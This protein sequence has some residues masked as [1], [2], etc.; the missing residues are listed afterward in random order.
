[1][2]LKNSLGKL[3]LCQK[4][5]ELVV[6]LLYHSC[7]NMGEKSVDEE[8][9]I[10]IKDDE[11]VWIEAIIVRKSKTEVICKIKNGDERIVKMKEFRRDTLPYVN[12][13]MVADLVEMKYLHEPGVLT[14]LISRHEDGKPYTR[15]RDVVISINPF[16]W[17]H[18]LYN[19]RNQQ[20]YADKLIWQIAEKDPRQ[21]LEPHIYEVSALA[22]AEMAF[23]G[24]NQSI[25]I[26][27]E[28]GSGKTEAV[29]LM[30][31]H[32]AR[33]QLGPCHKKS[34]QQ[35][36]STVAAV[37]GG[38]SFSDVV[39]RILYTNPLL[40][41]F[42]NAS[43]AQNENS[44]RFGK[45]VQLQFDNSELSLEQS[46]IP[47]KSVA[48]L[49]G[50]VCDVY[51]LETSRVCTHATNER[52]YHI[53]Y[54]LL[55]ASDAQKSLV[56]NGIVGKIADDFKY[57]GTPTTNAID[58]I[59]DAIKYSET[60]LAL[61]R[62]GIADGDTVMLMQTI[63]IVLQL[64]NIEFAAAY[65]DRA[66]VSTKSE[67]SNLSDLIGI[68]T[69]QLLPAFTQRTMTTRNETFNVPLS[70]SSAMEARDA[71]AK[72][73]YLN[74][75]TWLVEALNSKTRSTLNPMVNND[76]H[77]NGIIGLLDIFG[78]ESFTTNRFEQLC[79]NYANEKLQNK[80]L[81]DIFSS[82]REEYEYE[83][84]SL[85]LV[86]V[87]SNE[88]LLQL[89]DGRCGLIAL[90][91]EESYLPKG[92]SKSFTAKV[93]EKFKSSSL[94]TSPNNGI[95][96]QF[97]I[98][99]YAGTV[100]YNTDNFLIS[101]QDTLPIDL[102]NCICKCHNPI[103]AGSQ[104][105]ISFE[106]NEL[107]LPTSVDSTSG[108]TSPSITSPS[109]IPPLRSKLE[110]VK[111]SNMS[112]GRKWELE[113]DKFK[114]RQRS[115]ADIATNFDSLNSSSWK[116]L[117]MKPSEKPSNAM[118]T[119]NKRETIDTGSSNRIADTVWTKYRAQLNA[120][121]KT[122]G[123]THSRYVRCIKPNNTMIPRKCDR[124][125]ISKQLRYTGLVPT[126]ALS[127]A[128]FTKSISNKLLLSKFKLL[129]DV[130]KF[131]SKAKRFDTIGARRKLDCEALLLCL[132]MSHGSDLTPSGVKE[133]PYVVG[134]TRSYF[135][136][137]VLE[138]LEST[139]M[140][141]LERIITI[142]QKNFRG[143]LVRKRKA[144]MMLAASTI[145]FWFRSIKK[146]L[147]SLEIQRLYRGYTKKKIFL[148]LKRSTL[149]TQRFV[150]GFICRAKNRRYCNQQDPIP[151]IN[152]ARREIE[153]L[154][155]HIYHLAAAHLTQCDR[156][157]LIKESLE[158]RL[159]MA[160][161]TNRAWAAHLIPLIHSRIKAHHSHLQDI[162]RFFPVTHHD[163]LAQ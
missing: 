7:L 134:K 158:D 41:A 110:H 54:Q 42:G 68:S 52:T 94:I 108:S 112:I 80:A 89:L 19:E 43:T 151:Q 145:Q 33:I 114:K 136:Q 115:I 55:A 144:K 138:W 125:M 70:L 64:G 93:I 30:M 16:R 75:F 38:N 155:Y 149:I 32:L 46:S 146:T 31:H 123:D 132:S 76:Q 117:R 119:S 13:K 9:Q 60:L 56:W 148:A 154:L 133:L 63:C 139:R 92:S 37:T 161:S 50:S 86:E 21:D 72:N 102:K 162:R 131:P 53:F 127:R 26:T 4:L 1:M 23:Q 87:A 157:E 90:L 98:V 15:S 153:A 69:D 47:G 39:D 107:E 85:D 65:D 116:D 91:N 22:Y 57:V 126:I 79:I 122:L 140:R 66:D 36:A 129:W 101:N 163:A 96:N 8:Q 17:L 81:R 88:Q 150:R 18:H 71:L 104:K 51:L 49:V 137:G 120:L 67:F 106:H 121:M 58:G 156:H 3:K 12:S 142:I 78:F 100:M 83:G 118:T 20:I 45:H 141:T 48:G 113:Q 74:A 143:G 124:I 147:A 128:M 27:G 14:N 95:Y 59:S 105:L 159:L 28:S 6:G 29:K 2:G 160:E 35:S 73:I 130:Q 111:R 152:A 97:G 109:S 103:A 5:C 61:S 34:I 135:R 84:L 62:I 11:E 44:S 40:E 25:I 24:K 77:E 99:H 82:V 10:F